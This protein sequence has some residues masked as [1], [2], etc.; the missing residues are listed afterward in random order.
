MFESTLRDGWYAHEA[1]FSA[2]D[3]FRITARV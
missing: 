2:L 1:V 3:P